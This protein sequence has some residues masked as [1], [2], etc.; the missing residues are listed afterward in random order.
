MASIDSNRGRS[1][2]IRLFKR[3]WRLYVL[4][5]IPLIYQIIFCYFPMYGVQIAFRDYRP[6]SGIT[7]SEWVGLQ[8]FKQFLNDRQFGA[9]FSNT[10][11]LSLYS[12]IAS[13]PLPIIFALTLNC[14]RS[15][16]YKKTVQT[17]AYLPHFISTTV[18]VS[19]VMLLLSPVCGIYGSFYHLLGGSGY[20]VDFRSTAGAFRHLYVWSGV[21]QGLG[22]SSIIYTSALSAVPA[23][24]HEAAKIDGAS[25]FKRVLYVDLPA[26]APT[27]GIMFLMNVS[28]L[29]GVG[30]E[31]AYMMQTRLNLSTSEVLST[32]VYKYG[33]SSF[34]DYSFGA[35]VGL[36]NTGVNL[37]LL[38]IT[39][40]IVKKSSDG[41][42]ALF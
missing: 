28:G 1:R 29:I 17:I 14:L 6:R 15:E 42:I 5:M 18:M 13:F 23:E 12:M 37:L 41:E 10:V 31:K 26:I 32:F 7:G 36:F 20:P 3:D 16:K 9:V 21:W 39:N 11:I 27:I 22:W 34:R 8:W 40:A 24:L 38:V 33:M 19:I 2:F 35:A 30:F 25:R 4:I